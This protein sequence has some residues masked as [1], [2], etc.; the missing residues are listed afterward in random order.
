MSMK[1]SNDTVGNR[2]LDPPA[3]SIVSEL[4]SE[5]QSKIPYSHFLFLSSIFTARFSVQD[6]SVR[7]NECLFLPVSQERSV[8]VFFSCKKNPKPI[9][10]AKS[11]TREI[12]PF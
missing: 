12:Q 4:D 6:F 11:G 7:R 1:N 2:T 3:C 8:V 9:L 10:S 5:L